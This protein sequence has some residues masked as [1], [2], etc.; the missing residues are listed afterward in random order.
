METGEAPT[1]KLGSAISFQELVDNRLRLVYHFYWERK[2]EFKLP[3]DTYP[4]WVIFAVESGNFRYRIGMES[5]TIGQG[6]MVIC[7]PGYPLQREAITP[8]SLHYIGFEFEKPFPPDLAIPNFKL[9]PLDGN[10]FASDFYYLRKF[11]FGNDR[12]NLLRKQWFLNDMWQLA[13]LQWDTESHQDECVPLA[14]SNDDLMNR[15]MDWLLGNAYRQFAMRELTEQLGLSPVQFTRRFRRAFRMLPSD[16]IRN[17]R[18]R[19]A[20]K[21]LRDTD[22]TLEQIAERCGYDNGFYLGLAERI[23]NPVITRILTLFRR[24]HVQGN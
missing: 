21:L 5:G 20:A 13:C 24:N 17:L 2:E 12:G 10:R 6:E 11:H 8:L 16:L 23:K 7:P 14:N 18:I 3:V 19:K 22:M 15:A 1:V 9:H 4:V